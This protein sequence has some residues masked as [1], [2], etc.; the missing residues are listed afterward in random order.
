[1]KGIVVK[2]L[3]CLGT[4]YYQK[5][6][7]A[8]KAFLLHS[9]V[10]NISEIDAYKSVYI[11]GSG[12]MAYYAYQLLKDKVDIS[13]MVD[14]NQELIGRKSA[15]GRTYLPINRLYSDSDNVH[16]VIA[17]NR[18]HLNNN[19]WQL[20]VH[21][22]KSY[23]M[24]FIESCGDLSVGDNLI[25]EAVNKVIFKDEGMEKALPPVNNVS[26]MSDHFLGSINYLLS[27][28]AM[29]EP[30]FNYIA[31]Q[32]FERCLEI[33]PGMGI[34]SYMIAKNMQPEKIDW[35]VYEDHQKE[36]LEQQEYYAIYQQIKDNGIDLGIRSGKVEN[37]SFNLDDQ[38]DLLIMTEVIE[39]FTTNPLQVL[40]KIRRWM[41]DKAILCISTPDYTPICIYNSAD[42][43]PEY[44]AESQFYYP[45]HTY[46]YR[47]EELDRM[48]EEAGLR[49]VLYKKS[50]FGHH[51]YVLMKAN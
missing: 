12:G 45:G 24:F 25:T 37:P 19:R 11:L 38:Y 50:G 8:Q 30:C 51:N 13:G 2:M 14:N 34:F 6:N 1:M 15:D 40:H 3:E 49:T 32:R 28:T 42:E 4:L 46:Q 29:W 18:P 17:T 23:S 16:I 44:K 48:F 7:V 39:H 9:N 20:L 47:K 22:I 5:G 26:Y 41:I 31:R 35:I 10:N 43:I 33:G 27:S 36:M 21:G